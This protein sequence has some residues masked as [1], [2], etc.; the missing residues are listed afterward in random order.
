[1]VPYGTQIAFMS[2]R[3]GNWEIYRINIDGT[4]EI[5]LTN[6]PQH[7]VAPEW[8]LTSAP[9][10]DADGDGVSDLQDNCPSTANADQADTDNDGQGDACDGDDDNDTVADTADNC[11]LTANPGQAD[12]DSDGLGDVCNPT[13]S[14]TR[15]PHSSSTRRTIPA[16]ARATPPNA[17][18]ARQLRPP[19]LTGARRR[20]PSH[21]PGQRTTHHPTR[22]V[23]PNLADSVNILNTSGEKVSVRG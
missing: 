2:A 12:A 3:S 5:N 23:L 17:L 15:L 14:L 21:L 18:Y 16:P 1:M 22:L 11:P 19:T 7:D 4:G 9:S 10:P 6:D 13:E 20:S 8:T